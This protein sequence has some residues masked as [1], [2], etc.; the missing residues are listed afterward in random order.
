MACEAT[1]IYKQLAELVSQKWEESYLVIMRWMRCRLSFAL[2]SSAILCIRG[3]HSSF[4]RP[5]RDDN[6]SLAVA[7]GE[8]QLV[9][10]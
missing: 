8:L 5:V 1:V 9:D 2:L 10:S 7:E 3:S 6:S 4:G